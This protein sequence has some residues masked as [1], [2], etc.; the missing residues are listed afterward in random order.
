MKLDHYDCGGCKLPWR[1]TESVVLVRSR[2]GNTPATGAGKARFYVPSASMKVTY[3]LVLETPQA[4]AEVAPES[5]PA[6]GGLWTVYP[7]IEDPN[8]AGGTGRLRKVRSSEDVPDSVEIETGTGWMYVE[9]AV[10]QVANVSATGDW[11]LIV[12]WELLAC[13]EPAARQAIF[14][15][16]RLEAD[17]APIIGTST[18]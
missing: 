3:A 8:R 15:Q 14:A 2:G 18:G 5:I 1:A 11:V 16:C 6:G 7:R 9:L 17:P 12:V 10:D 4:T 13:V